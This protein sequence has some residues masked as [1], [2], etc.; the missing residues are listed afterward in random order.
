MMIREATGSSAPLSDRNA[1]SVDV[2]ARLNPG[3]S[4]EQARDDLR[5]L[6]VDMAREHPESNK[7]RSAM[8]F[9]QL[10]YRIAEAPDNFAISWLFFAIAALALSIACVN[11]ANLLLS[12]A[13]ARVREIAVRMAL[14][15]SRRRL[16][17]QFLIESAVLSTLGAM[18]ASASRRRVRRSFDRFN[19]RATFR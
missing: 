16:L 6:A 9:T 15:A 19:S 17:G 4:I 10:G 8:A 18:A 12:T 2:F 5:R 7:G 11:V 3:V 14:G 1:R 13:P